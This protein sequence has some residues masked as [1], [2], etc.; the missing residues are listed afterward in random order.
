MPLFGR[1]IQHSNLEHFLSGTAQTMSWSSAVE[2]TVTGLGYDLVDV[3]RSGGGLLRVL[4]Q[5]VL[6]LLEVGW[7][8]H[9]TFRFVEHVG[10]VAKVVLIPPMRGTGDHSSEAAVDFVTAAGSCPKIGFAAAVFVLFH[11]LPPH[12]DCHNIEGI[13]KQG[14]PF[15]FLIFP[16]SISLSSSTFFF[17]SEKSLPPLL[18]SPLPL[19]PCLSSANCAKGKGT[20]IRSREMAP[21]QTGGS[22][23]VS[24]AWSPL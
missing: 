5:T 22:A 9:S 1:L 7:E 17:R 13:A 2:R 19:H 23:V 10:F 16:S 15:H 12:I 21:S 20:E 18:S 24:Q 6:G 4:F 8:V 3:E 14:S 11:H